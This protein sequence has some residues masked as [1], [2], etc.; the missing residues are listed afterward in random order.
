MIEQEPFCK[1][2]THFYHDVSRYDTTGFVSIVLSK[3]FGPLFVVSITESV[4]T[5]SSI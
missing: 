4:I 2:R 1:V 3:L 5:N